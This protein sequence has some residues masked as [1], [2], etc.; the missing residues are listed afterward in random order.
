MD[1][2]KI[3]TIDSTSLEQIHTELI[4]QGFEPVDDDLKEWEGPLFPSFSNLTD[5]KQMKIVFQDGWPFLHPKV[6]VAGLNC[7]H[8]NFENEVCLWRD[9]DGNMDWV[10]FDG[11]R[12]KVDQWC[13]LAENGFRDEDV[14]LD[15]HLYYENIGQKLV[16]LDINNI[17]GEKAVDGDYGN[18]FAHNINKEC[19]KIDTLKKNSNGRVAWYYRTHIIKPP[20]NIDSFKKSLHSR[21]QKDFTRLFLATRKRNRD[22]IN[23]IVLLWPYKNS[24]NVQIINI[25]FDRSSNLISQALVAAPIDEQY[26]TLRA[27][28]QFETF[29]KLNIAIFGVGAIGSHVSILLCKMGIGLLKLI[30]NGL[31]RPSLIFNSCKS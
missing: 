11:I 4:N 10:T 31:I 27:G 18:L 6:F 28:H 5:A 20:H 22:A 7:E 26:L 3:N 17:I 19:V 29:N 8:V 21:Q 12:S 30:D 13:A 23:Y 16:L 1:L 14:V 2:A 25:G 24:F 9:D 15:A